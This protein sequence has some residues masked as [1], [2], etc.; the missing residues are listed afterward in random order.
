[1]DLTGRRWKQ[2]ARRGAVP[3]HQQAKMIIA[4]TNDNVIAVDFSS[5]KARKAA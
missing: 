2:L 4:N 3:R 5:R 1:M